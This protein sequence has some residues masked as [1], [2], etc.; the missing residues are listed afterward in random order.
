MGVKTLA[1]SVKNHV[2]LGEC[3]FSSSKDK[4][5]SHVFGHRIQALKII[6]QYFK[7]PVAESYTSKGC[8]ACDNCAVYIIH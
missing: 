2:P 7:T 8:V 1:K 3:F 5:Q 4:Q 6:I